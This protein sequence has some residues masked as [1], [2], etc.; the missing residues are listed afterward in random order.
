MARVLVQMDTD[1]GTGQKYPDPVV[2]ATVFNDAGAGAEFG[3]AADI[4]TLAQ[5]EGA[6]GTYRLIVGKDG[7]RT[8]PAFVTGS[9]GVTFTVTARGPAGGD[10]V[11]TQTITLPA[12]GYFQWSGTPD[13]VAALM[14]T[15]VPA[16]STLD[17][18]ITQGSGLA[19]D[20]VTNNLTNDSFFKTATKYTPI[21][22]T[23]TGIDWNGDGIPDDVDA[24]H[25]GVLDTVINVSCSAPFAYQASLITQPP[26]SYSYVGSNMPAGMSLVQ[27]TG[28]I[29]YTPPCSTMGSTFRPNFF[30]TAN[31][32]QLLIAQFHVTQ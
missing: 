15:A 5:V 12:N 27:G 8:N 10:P 13:G 31:S 9:Q 3:Q 21:T 23:I 17:Y 14:G 6:T 18:V 25:N 2:D 30:V 32:T 11:A 7:T 22:P 28:Q 20:T 16:N 1:P 19:S 4:Y 24:D 26:G 29:V